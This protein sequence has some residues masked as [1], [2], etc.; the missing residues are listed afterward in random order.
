MLHW[1]FAIANKQYETFRKLLLK[2]NVSRFTYN[3]RDSSTKFCNSLVNL[4]KNTE[5]DGSK[6][7][8]QEQEYFE[9]INSLS[10]K[11]LLSSKIRNEKWFF[12][13]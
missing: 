10:E 1:Y 7:E 12:N 3:T 2:N 13:H 9:Y 11:K 4:K 6:G 8:P 5:S